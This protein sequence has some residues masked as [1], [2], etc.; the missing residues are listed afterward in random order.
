MGDRIKKIREAEGKNQREFAS[1]I[2][3]GQSTLA[4][5][6]NGQREPKSIHI[7]QICLKYDINEDWLRT[8]T[9]PMYREP[10]EKL[11]TYLG[12][13]SKGDDDFIK[14]LIEVYMELDQTSKDALKEIAR[15]MAEKAESRGQ[16]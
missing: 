3:V 6:E 12:R 16:E 2:K 5:F 8:G 1:S 11:E 14:D 13:I 4:M 15:R 9:L 7:E 10:E